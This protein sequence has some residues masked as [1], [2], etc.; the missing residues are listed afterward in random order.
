M[1]YKINKTESG[2][3]VIIFEK[4]SYSDY[5]DF[6]DIT[7]FINNVDVKEC[8]LNISDVD[9]IDSAVL[10]MFLI[11]NDKAKK[12]EISLVI[13]GAKDRVKEV[14]KSTKLDDIIKFE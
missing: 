3:E 13:K 5:D 9:F 4:I 10:G 8:I 6:F 7:S 2:Y 11:L 1:K 14:I 12:N